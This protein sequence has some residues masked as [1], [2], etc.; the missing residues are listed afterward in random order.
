MGTLL[1]IGF[2]F[3]WSDFQLGQWSLPSEGE[4][5]PNGVVSGGVCGQ[6]PA[7]QPAAANYDQVQAVGLTEDK[8]VMTHLSSCESY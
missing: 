8:S 4:W 1:R 7:F 5:G 3:F 6:H 2:F